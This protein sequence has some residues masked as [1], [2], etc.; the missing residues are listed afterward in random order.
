MQ[1]RHC[2]SQESALVLATYQILEEKQD[3]QFIQIVCHAIASDNISFLL[4]AIPNKDGVWKTWR[5]IIPIDIQFNY[6]IILS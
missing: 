4:T 2:I 5:H 3:E 1:K 6:C